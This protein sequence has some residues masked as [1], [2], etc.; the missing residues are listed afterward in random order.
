MDR[1]DWDEVAGRKA[2]FVSRLLAPM[3]REA[4]HGVILDAAYKHDGPDSEHVALMVRGE[5]KP[6]KVNVHMDSE[7]AIVKDVMRVVADWYE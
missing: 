2:D 1:P 6:V 7:W 4:T 3:L 5:L